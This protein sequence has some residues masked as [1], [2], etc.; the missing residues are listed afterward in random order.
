MKDNE[1]RV[2]LETAHKRR[3]GRA[4]TVRSE[5]SPPIERVPGEIVHGARKWPNVRGQ[6]AR[7]AG[8]GEPHSSE[9]FLSGCLASGM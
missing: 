3:N 9:I 2:S 6:P 5:P 4:T 8:L 1:S 7:V